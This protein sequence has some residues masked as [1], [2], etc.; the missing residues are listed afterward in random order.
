MNNVVNMREFRVKR[1]QAQMEDAHVRYKR[2][3][4]SSDEAWKLLTE[5]REAEKGF[6]TQELMDFRQP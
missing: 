3:A 4:V 5:L 2:G 1:L 6:S